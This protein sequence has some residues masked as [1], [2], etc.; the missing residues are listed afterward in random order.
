MKKEILEI[1][2]I[3]KWSQYTCSFKK[4][5]TNEEKLCG[6]ESEDGGACFLTMENGIIWCCITSYAM[7]FSSLT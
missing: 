3:P 2:Y 4:D 6:C 7:Y 1:Q 5:K